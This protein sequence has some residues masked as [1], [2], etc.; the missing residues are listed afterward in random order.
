MALA[1]Q[2]TQPVAILGTRTMGTAIARRLIDTGMAV[3]VWNRSPGPALALA[4]LGA[5]VFEDPREAVSAAMVVVTL[6]PTPQIVT[7]LMIGRNVVDAMAPGATWA[8]M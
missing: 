4:A 5:T 8:Q 7:D 3:A 1:Q 6:L 2:P